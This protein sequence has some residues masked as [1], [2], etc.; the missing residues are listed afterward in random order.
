MQLF[1]TNYGLFRRVALE[2]RRNGPRA[3]GAGRDASEPGGEW[4]A[5]YNARRPHSALDDRT[6]AEHPIMK[7]LVVHVVLR[8]GEM[9]DDIE[10]QNVT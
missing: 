9:T 7:N 4:F 3:P 1:H 2:G 6:P 10:Q 5:C 8:L